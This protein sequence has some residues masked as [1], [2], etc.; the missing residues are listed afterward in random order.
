MKTILLL[1]VLL[2]FVLSIAGE[3]EDGL[4]C[5]IRFIDD[6]PYKSSFMPWVEDH[7]R[8][9]FRVINLTDCKVAVRKAAPC[10]DCNPVLV[11][12]DCSTGKEPFIE[13]RTD[14]IYILT[15]SSFLDLPPQGVYEDTI[16]FAK[17]IEYDLCQ[18]TC[19]RVWIEWRAWYNDYQ[20]EDT[21]KTVSI[22]PYKIVSDT[23]TFVR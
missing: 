8:V 1:L 6:P 23:L 2:S 7:F 12:R 14:V 19:Y 3:P 18:D 5:K 16:D 9:S 21:S 15:D 17:Y 22:W 11:I 13:N 10:D 20:F 4:T